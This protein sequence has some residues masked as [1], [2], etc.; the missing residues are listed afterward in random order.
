MLGKRFGLRCGGFVMGSVVLGIGLGPG[1]ALAKLKL[2]KA[3]TQ[4]LY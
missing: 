3:P 1:D 4:E 2:N